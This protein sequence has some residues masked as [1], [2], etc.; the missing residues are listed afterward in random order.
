MPSIEASEV[1]NYMRSEADR[2]ADSD[3]SE[4][5][6]TLREMVDRIFL[7]RENK[8]TS[9]LTALE[10]EQGTVIKSVRVNGIDCEW[11]YSLSANFDSRMLYLHGGGLLAGS[12][13]T[14]RAM[15]SRIAERTG[16]AILLP[17]YRL[18]PEAPYPAALEDSVNLVNWLSENSPI[19]THPAKN[20]FLAGDS[21]GGGLALSVM[22]SCRELL[23]KL[24]TA[25]ATL[26]ALTDFTAS[27]TSMA[28]NAD[29]DALLSAEAVRG[30]GAIYGGETPANEP[31]LSPLFGDT[32]GLPP[33]HMQV[34]QVEVLR[35]DSVNFFAKHT[36][37]GGSGELKI[38]PGMV[39][40]WQSFAPYL[41][42]AEDALDALA[43]F[44][45]QFDKTV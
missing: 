33:L 10:L 12:I 8:T 45:K 21:A 9:M 41:P 37:S 30:I 18:G 25:A 32:E 44:F 13:A 19:G 5:V 7:G 35:D 29:N 34:S 42:E 27:S 23:T 15:V 1:E 22:V 17:D 20:I 43:A 11:I 38:Y 40:V 6:V 28:S 31:K 4:F 14:H 26:C 36:A 16:F 24:P 3:P 2:L 39:H